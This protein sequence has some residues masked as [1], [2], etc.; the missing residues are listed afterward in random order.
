MKILSHN[1][2]IMFNCLCLLWCHVLNYA[3]F[4]RIK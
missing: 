1:L 3:E 2:I 4:A